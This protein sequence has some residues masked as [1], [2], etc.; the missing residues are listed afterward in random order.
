M[1]S[2]KLLELIKEKILNDL[3]IFKDKY[4]PL[5]G[6]SYKENL[7]VEV[8]HRKCKNYFYFE[9][10]IEEHK[11][12]KITGVKNSRYIFS[13]QDEFGNVRIYSFN[14]NKLPQPTWKVELRPISNEEPEKG[15]EDVNVAYFHIK[16][17]TNLTSLLLD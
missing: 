1:N 5:D 17:A 8:K 2:D 4:A 9:L 15:M 16:D 7:W 14:F 10:M 3:Y 6:Y 12:I 11:Y 13:M